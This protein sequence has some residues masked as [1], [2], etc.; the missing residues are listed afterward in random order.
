MTEFVEQSSFS[1]LL[2][3]CGAFFGGLTAL[4]TGIG[5]AIESRL[6][7]SR[8][9]FDLPRADGQLRWELMGN[10]R[11]VVMAAFAFA[12]LLSVVPLA[13]ES[14]SSFFSGWGPRET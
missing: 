8:R 7:S 2:L 6:N 1:Q 14:M 3:V 12:A 11:F 13:E 4:Y 9:I 10:V 5:F